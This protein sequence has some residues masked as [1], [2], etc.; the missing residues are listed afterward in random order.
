M[1][2]FVFN[3]A[4]IYHSITFLGIFLLHLVHCPIFLLCMLDDI[5]IDELV[6]ICSKCQYNAYWNLFAASCRTI[7]WLAI[8]M[9]LLVCLWILCKFFSLWGLNLSVYQ[10]LIL[11]YNF[12][13]MLLTII[14]VD[15][16]L[17][18]LVPFII[19]CKYYAFFLW[20]SN[21]LSNA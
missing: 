15:G 9:L 5:S 20:N 4:E 3:D 21:L 13:E 14:S 8:S 6:A 2:A 11:L 12:P 17:M 10:I 16:Y 1:F 18:N 7:N 19:S